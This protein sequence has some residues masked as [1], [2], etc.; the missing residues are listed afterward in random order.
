M[1]MS[2]FV[3]EE[4]KCYSLKMKIPSSMEWKGKNDTDRF[5]K[6]RARCKYSEHDEVDKEFYVNG[7]EFSELGEEENFIIRKLIV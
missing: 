6:F 4:G 3:L 7:F 2:E 5:I 1:V